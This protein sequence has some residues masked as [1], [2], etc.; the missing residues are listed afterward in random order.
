MCKRTGKFT[1][2]LII[3]S[4]AITVVF[5]VLSGQGQ[6]EL[7]EPVALTPR[8][9]D[10]PAD[11]AIDPPKVTKSISLGEQREVRLA[12]YNIHHGADAQGR[13]NL[14]GTLSEIKKLDADI[15]FLTEVD[16]RNV[17][18]GLVDQAEFLAQGGDYPYYFF[19]PA[20]SNYGTA[21][22]SRFPIIDAQRYRLP[23][24]FGVEPRVLLEA[25]LSVYGSELELYGVHLTLDRGLRLKQVDSL[26]RRAF[27]GQSD[28]QVII[29][30]FNV[31]VDA[32]EIE[33]M[34]QAGFSDAAASQGQVIQTFPASEPRHQID[35]IFVSPALGGLI[36]EVQ[37]PRTLKSDHLPYA[38]SFSWP[39]VY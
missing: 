26:L 20:L 35:Y 39:K 37:V 8:V 16:V 28:D 31:A 14:E 3:A 23:N 36:T 17:R 34:N 7:A 19:A 22:L 9:R 10:F 13:Q 11:L 4:L 33:R 27:Q 2:L 15:L 25:T 29:G 21:L 24:R 12:T 1:D 38:A 18:S 30:D 32:P 6:P 5:L